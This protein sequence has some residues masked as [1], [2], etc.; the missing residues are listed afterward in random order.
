MR[1][2]GKTDSILIKGL[3]LA[4]FC[5][6]HFLSQLQKDVQRNPRFLLPEIKPSTHN[7]ISAFGK[8]ISV[9]KS[10]FFKIDF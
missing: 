5:P 8:F 1:I 2:Q 9:F 10:R 4:A 3:A 6:L 7:A